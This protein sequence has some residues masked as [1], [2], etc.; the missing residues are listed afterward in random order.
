MLEAFADK[1]EKGFNWNNFML[2]K[3]VDHEGVE[4]RV[5]D[6]YQRN[7]EIIDL[8]AQPDNIKTVLDETIVTQVQRV[9]NTGVGVHFMKFC[10]K[11][12]LQR[13]S[14]TAEAH[15]EYLNAAY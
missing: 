3:W 13:I 2:Q 6:D 10:G 4:H 12:D 7:R 1:N 15:A 14:A 11:H 9:P 5:L 8:T